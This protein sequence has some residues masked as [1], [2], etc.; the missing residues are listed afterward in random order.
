[1][2]IA[3]MIMPPPFK[4]KKDGDPEQLLQDFMEYRE[5]YDKF[6]LATG[7]AG[8]HSADHVDCG[9]CKKSKAMLEL[10]GGWEMALF[11]HTG[12]VEEEDTYVRAM[13]KVANGIKSQTKQAMV[14]YKLFQQMKQ[15]KKLF[16]QG[17][18][19]IRE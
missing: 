4:V 13:E 11:K 18:T 17:Y 16:Q 5:I 6:L 8:E 10:V 1:M 12:K 14:R 15:G 3:A 7:V 2:A 9:I 19:E